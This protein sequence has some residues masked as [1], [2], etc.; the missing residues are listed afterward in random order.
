MHEMLARL[1][2]QANADSICSWGNTCIYWDWGFWLGAIVGIVG[3]IV[4]YLSK[5]GDTT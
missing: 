2:I 1:F 3:G 4:L 5:T